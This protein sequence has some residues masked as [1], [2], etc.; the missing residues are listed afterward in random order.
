MFKKKELIIYTSSSCGYCKTTKEKLDEAGMKY[1]ERDIKEYESEWN[2]LV[3][4]TNMPVTPGVVY[5]DMYLF[6]SRDFP[7]PEMLVK[8]LENPSKDNYN[9]DL[10]S[11]ERLKTLNYH[12]STAFNGLSQRLQAIENQLKENKSKPKKKKNVNKST[13]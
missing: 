13:S 3:M 2:S 8:I 4:L 11:L 10:K 7:N 12:I 6:P 1:I 5:N 9:N